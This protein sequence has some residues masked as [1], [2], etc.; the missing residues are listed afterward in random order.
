MIYLTLLFTLLFIFMV[1]QAG[2]V[3]MTYI[4]NRNYPGGPVAYFLASQALPIN[5]IF[6]ATFVLLTFFADSLIVS[7]LS[8]H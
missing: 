8:N 4:D 2:A 1:V 3:Q 5:V 6:L 7:L